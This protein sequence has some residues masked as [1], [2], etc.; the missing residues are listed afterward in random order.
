LAGPIILRGDRI[1]GG[2]PIRLSCA[3][4]IF[5]DG[6][7]LMTQRSDNG[8]WCLPSGALDSG[9]SVEEACCREALEETGLTIK[10]QRLIG[11]YSDPNRVFAYPDKRWHVV[12]LV[13]AASIVNGTPRV[14]PETLDLKFCTR[15]ETEALDLL[16]HERERLSDL[17]GQ[18]LQPVI[19]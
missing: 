7:L 19:R 6:R 10:V 15:Q 11:I 9:E 5:E 13:F 8:R 18:N 14:T 4:A 16:E 12:E 17:F 3:A 1:A 2:E